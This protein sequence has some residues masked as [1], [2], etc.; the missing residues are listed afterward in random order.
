[1][2]YPFKD[3]VSKCKQFHVLSV[4][5]FVF[6][7]HGSFISEKNVQH[8]KHLYPYEVFRENLRS[9][10]V[11]LILSFHTNSQNSMFCHYKYITIII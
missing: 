5:S 11:N 3:F 9:C 2:M 8:V 4:D 10:E 1:M 7:N 6:L